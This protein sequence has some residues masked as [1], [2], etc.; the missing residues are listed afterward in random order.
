[1]SSRFSFIDAR[2]S[3][4][5]DPTPNSMFDWF[6]A[7]PIAAVGAG[8]WAAFKWL[9][10]RVMKM[11]ASREARIEA[12]EHEYVKKL[13]ARITELERND[14]QRA[15][16]NVALRLAFEVVA[17]EVRRTNPD[18]SELKRAEAILTAAFGMP[19]DT[20]ADMISALA[21]M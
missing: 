13:E 8:L 19:M 5:S 15:K 3:A 4:M 16:E 9:W 14:H 10:D 6:L 2:R 21:K 1:M 7:A 17:A 20:P 12:R 11:R 18:S